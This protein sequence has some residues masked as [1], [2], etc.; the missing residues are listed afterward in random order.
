MIFMYRHPCLWK[1]CHMFFFLQFR[2]LYLTRSRCRSTCVVTFP[3]ALLFYICLSIHYFRL[4]NYYPCTVILS[5]LIIHA[6]ESSISKKITHILGR[7]SLVYR[8]HVSKQLH[9]FFHCSWILIHSLQKTH[10][11]FKCVI[12]W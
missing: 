7:R 8:P 9:P 2:V 10:I 11:S 6:Q 1:L 5:A 3:Q 12:R 4:R